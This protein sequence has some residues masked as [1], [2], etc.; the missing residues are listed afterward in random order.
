MKILFL[1]SP[2]FAKQDM[3]DAFEANQITCDLFYHKDYKERHSKEFEEAFAAAL[4][5]ASYFLL[6]IPRFF[7]HAVRTTTSNMSPISMTAH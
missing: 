7:L 6:I 1:D 2:A 5:N 4:T 3:I